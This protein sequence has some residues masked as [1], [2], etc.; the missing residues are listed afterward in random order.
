MSISRFN[1]G[2]IFG[3]YEIEQVIGSGGFGIVYSAKNMI[4]DQSFALKAIPL[5]GS[6]GNVTEMLTEIDVMQGLKHKNVVHMEKFFQNTSYLFVVMELVSGGDLRK[7][8]KRNPDGLPIE[9]V[10]SFTFQ[11]AEAFYYLRG[12][13]IV[14][15]DLKPENILVD[16]EGN[17]KIADFGMAKH[18]NTQSLLSSQGE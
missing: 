4:N 15:L 1:S 16:G 5:A 3:T 12:E 9:Q 8:L 2:D 18:A 11:L 6:F 10:R 17:L 14:H 7:I 13:R